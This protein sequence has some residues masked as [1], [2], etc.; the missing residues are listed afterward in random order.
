VGLSLSRLRFRPT[1]IE[2][3]RLP[4]Q[5]I[6]FRPIEVAIDLQVLPADMEGV[7]AGAQDFA[8][9]SDYAAGE[10]AMR[11]LKLLASGFHAALALS[12]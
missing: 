8:R 11:V 3:R 10:F 9:P 5:P 6:G 1:P 7:V 2:P 12:R 4:R